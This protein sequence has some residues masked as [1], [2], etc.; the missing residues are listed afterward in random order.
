VPIDLPDRSE[1]TDADYRPVFDELEQLRES[2]SARDVPLVLL[3]VNRQEESG[4]FSTDEHR[5]NDFVARYCEATDLPLANPLPRMEEEARGRPIFRT[6]AD[7]HWTPAAHR[8]AAETV[9]ET[10]ASEDLL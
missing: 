3:I 8:I 6:P 7:M 9:L 10:V 4:T 2:L 5:Y 1:W